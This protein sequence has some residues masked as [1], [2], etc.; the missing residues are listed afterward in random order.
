MIRYFP[1]T[2]E[3]KEDQQIDNFLNDIV[4]V[5]RKYGLS[6]SHEDEHGSFI[7]TDYDKTYSEWLLAASVRRSQGSVAP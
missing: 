4:Q 1:D 6:I 3:E 2:R 5:C 7:V